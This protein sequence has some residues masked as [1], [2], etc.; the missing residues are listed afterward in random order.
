M[1]VLDRRRLLAAGA[2]LA[3]PGIIGA[4][5]A[6]AIDAANAVMNAGRLM[7]CWAGLLTLNLPGT[8]P[9]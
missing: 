3:A 6:E 4:R 7:P 8:S 2:A 1:T 9:F 5:A